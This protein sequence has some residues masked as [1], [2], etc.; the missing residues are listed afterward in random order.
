[1]ALLSSCAQAAKAA[2]TA[3]TVGS[4]LHL[5][6]LQGG[7][8]ELLVE[9]GNHC[10][11]TMLGGKAWCP[12]DIPSSPPAPPP[13]APALTQRGAGSRRRTGSGHRLPPSPHG[14]SPYWAGRASPRA[15]FW[16]VPCALHCV[17]TRTFFFYRQ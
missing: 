12:R 5:S 14:P 8:K 16:K 2:K 3:G 4:R 6:G 7:E 15:S 1:M 10:V 9:Q 13:A 11:T 17:N